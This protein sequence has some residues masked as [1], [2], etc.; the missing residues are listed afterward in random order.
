MVNVYEIRVELLKS[1]TEDGCTSCHVD[2]YYELE[3]MLQR[4]DASG[5]VSKADDGALCATADLLLML[6]SGCL[7]KRSWKRKKHV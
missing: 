2:P 6:N 3:T 7:C 5:T 1:V 4:T